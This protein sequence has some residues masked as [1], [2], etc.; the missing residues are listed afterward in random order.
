M[1]ISTTFLDIITVAS[2]D[3]ISAVLLLAEDP[4]CECVLCARV[5]IVLGPVILFDHTIDCLL[6][7]VSLTHRVKEEKA[8]LT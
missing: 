5:I 7:F 3:P 2:A 8:A 6:L 1:E 4:W